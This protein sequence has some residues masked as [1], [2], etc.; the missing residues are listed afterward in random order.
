MSAP[1][2]VVHLQKQFSPPPRLTA[3]GGQQAF[4]GVLR[5][6]ARVLYAS[7]IL[8]LPDRGGAA[9]GPSPVTIR[10]AVRTG[11]SC[12]PRTRRGAACIRT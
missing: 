10:S 4:S 7:S 12:A 1:A 3:A 11:S 2:P 9:G 6:Y 8:I 5:R